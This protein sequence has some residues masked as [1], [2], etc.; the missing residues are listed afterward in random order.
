VIERYRT[1]RNCVDVDLVNRR[2]LPGRTSMHCLF[3]LFSI[4]ALSSAVD[5]TLHDDKRCY[6]VHTNCCRDGSCEVRRQ[7]RQIGRDDVVSCP[8]SGQ[9]LQ[10]AFCASDGAKKK[11]SLCDA[12]R[13]TTSP[14][15]GPTKHIKYSAQWSEYG[16]FLV[17]QRFSSRDLPEIKLI[18]KT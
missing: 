12:I 10:Q 14:A 8:P 16:Q 13:L 18:Q 15:I 17:S 9:H 3:L 2:C 11:R 1:F 6:V 7:Q 4:F 5:S